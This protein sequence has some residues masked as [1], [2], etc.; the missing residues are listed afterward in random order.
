MPEPVRGLSSAMGKGSGKGSAKGRGKGKG[1][2][3]KLEKPVD[4]AAVPNGMLP[5][6][7]GQARVQRLPGALGN[8]CLAQSAL[9]P[10]ALVR[11]R[12][13][14]RG[15]S[16]VGYEQTQLAKFSAKVCTT[17]EPFRL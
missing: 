1:P 16:T 8:G 17:T 4:P 5:A 6:V 2:P 7:S 10:G 13:V 9:A 15:L 11:G 3:A 14:D 12:W